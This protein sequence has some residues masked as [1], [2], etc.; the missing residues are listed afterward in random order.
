MHSRSLGI[1]AFVHQSTT[2]P[3]GEQTGY[4]RSLL[5]AAEEV[6]I[7]A[8][9]FGPEN[10]D[11][12]H[13]T[14][15]VHIPA[16]NRWRLARRRLPRLIYDR[17]FLHFPRPGVLRQYRRLRRAG[18]FKFLN[19]T[20]PDKWKVHRVLAREEPVRR[21]L[22]PTQPY[23][24]AAQLLRCVRLWGGVVAKPVHGMK[25]RG[26][27]FVH[28][29][30]GE[31]IVRRGTRGRMFMSEGRFRQWARER[32]GKD[33]I[34]QRAL[35]LRDSQGR[36]FDIR[37][38]AQR[39]HRGELLITGAGIRLGSPGSLVSN[40]HQGGQ[41]VT[42]DQGVALIPQLASPG[43]NNVTAKKPGSP[44]TAAA[45][46]RNYLYSAALR[47]ARALDRHY[48][49]LAE[50][51]LDFG[52]DLMSRRLYFIEANSRPG[53]FIFVRMGDDAARE[54]AI[55]RPLEYARFLLHGAPASP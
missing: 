53:R 54:L 47:V 27:W 40:L 26:L 1:L 29:E 52:F 18:V 19:P 32:L 55:R 4:I 12:S 11:L 3:F 51:G 14:V 8:S 23:R 37:V 20:L 17:F 34:L 13:G 21:L 5:E 25:G 9:A 39:D 49:P 31:I 6:G 48:G 33:Y 15:T 16:G 41:A 2:R 24:D 22:P 43:N 44:G 46:F 30:D 50:A 42:I 38:L 10:V 7:T 36:P 28:L 35:F 45:T